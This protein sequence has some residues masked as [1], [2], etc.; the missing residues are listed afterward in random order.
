MKPL[1][2]TLRHREILGAQAIRSF[3]TLTVSRAGEHLCRM[4]RAL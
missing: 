2:N 1:D 3:V 4:L